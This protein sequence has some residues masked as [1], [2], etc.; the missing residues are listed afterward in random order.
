[1]AFTRASLLPNSVRAGNAQRGNQYV[2]ALAFAE[3][4]RAGGSVE[5]DAGSEGV[6]DV[7]CA[8]ACRQP[9]SG[10]RY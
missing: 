4:E 3:S 8:L 1:M 7:R 10:L 2:S 6:L 5:V 9:T